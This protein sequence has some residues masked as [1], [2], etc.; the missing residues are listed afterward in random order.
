MW[1]M[2]P[3][4]TEELLE[5]HHPRAQHHCCISLIV[6]PPPP[7][8]PALCLQAAR[9]ICAQLESLTSSLRSTQRHATL[10]CPP[11]LPLIHLHLTLT[12]P[13]PPSLLPLRLAS[14]KFGSLD[15]PYRHQHQQLQ[16]P[17]LNLSPSLLLLCA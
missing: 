5:K 4:G 17:G 2:S 12:P 10:L 15:Y 16:T 11:H 6:T 9:G 13:P 1:R 8:P 3:P 14:D 7:P